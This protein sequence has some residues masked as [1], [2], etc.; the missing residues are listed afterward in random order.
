MLSDSASVTTDTLS[1]YPHVPQWY[2]LSRNV[3]S[4]Q[5][6]LIHDLIRITPIYFSIVTNSLDAALA[7]RFSTVVMTVADEAAAAVLA[8]YTFDTA[9]GHPARSIIIS[10]DVNILTAVYADREAPIHVGTA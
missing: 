4:A 1:F 6:D 7:L 2:R 9:E 3:T 8:Q 10:G 5:E